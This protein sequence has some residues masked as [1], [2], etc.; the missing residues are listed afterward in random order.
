MGQR[1]HLESGGLIGRLALYYAFKES[2][3][4][5]LCERIFSNTF[6]PYYPSPA[7]DRFLEGVVQSAAGS[8]RPMI[9]NLAVTARCPCSCCH[10]SFSDRHQQDGLDLSDFK[11]IISEAQELGV[12]LIGITGGEPLPRDDL[13]DIIALVGERSMLVLFTTGY[14]LTHERVRRRRGSPR[15]ARA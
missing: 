5:R 14:G 12:S 2:K 6:T 4:T 3:L 9:M 8:P 15:H 10:C 7:Y 1:C 11:S 13:E